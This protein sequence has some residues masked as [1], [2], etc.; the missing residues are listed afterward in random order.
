MYIVRRFS[1]IPSAITPLRSNAP[2]NWKIDIGRITAE[3]EH[4]TGV[5]LGFWQKFKLSALYNRPEVQDHIKQNLINPQSN[6]PLVPRDEEEFR[7]LL[8]PVTCSMFL[9]VNHL[10][11]KYV[12]LHPTHAEDPENVRYGT[13]RIFPKGWISHQRREPTG[14]TLWTFLQGSSRWSGA[15]PSLHQNTLMKSFLSSKKTKM[16]FQHT[17]ATATKRIPNAIYTGVFSPRLNV[18]VWVGQ[19]FVDM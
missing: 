7:L 9:R 19:F 2:A 12:P 11:D 3:T 4:Q 14:L 1:R 5:D 8:N 6:D 17:Q 18:M 16:V 10:M 13:N 15:I